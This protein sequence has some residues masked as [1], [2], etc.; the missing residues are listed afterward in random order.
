MKK[1]FFAAALMCAAFAAFAQEQPEWIR[2]PLKY[3]RENYEGKKMSDETDWGYAV[4]LSNL[5]ASEGRSRSRS[6]EECMKSVATA[7]AGVITRNIEET[8]FSEFVDNAEFPDGADPEAALKR[9]EAALQIS[10]SRFKIPKIEYLEYHTEKIET[11]SGKKGY[12]TYVLGR[13]LS[14]ELR[15]NV[16]KIDVEKAVRSATRKFEK[17][18]N[19]KIP[20]ECKALV[21]ACIEEEKIEYLE[22]LP[23]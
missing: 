12:K 17:D 11:G 2:E 21:V 18:E 5:A 4:G 22:S 14:S 9:Y 16:E 6:E 7:V 15:R 1:S 3:G 20:D 13:Y 10:V 8:V 19:I 23:D